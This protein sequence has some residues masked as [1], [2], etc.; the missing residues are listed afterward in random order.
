LIIG[1]LKLLCFVKNNQSLENEL[2]GYEELSKLD[3]ER[4]RE[5]ERERRIYYFHYKK[6]AY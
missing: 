4:E 3:R 5:R 6:F 2:K 1:Y